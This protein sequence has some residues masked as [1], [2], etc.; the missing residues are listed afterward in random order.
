MTW[1]FYGCSYTAGHE[2]NDTAV[3]NE[4]GTLT[5]PVTTNK[6]Y[7]QNRKDSWAGT[8]C[9]LKNVEFCNRAEYGSS[10]GQMMTD[11]LSDIEQKNIERGDV[12]VWAST[13]SRRWFDIQ[14]N[15]SKSW[16]PTSLEMFG[17]SKQDYLLETWSDTHLLYRFFL[18]LYQFV[19]I[20]HHEG[21]ECM[22]I[23]CGDPLQ[24]ELRL[25]IEKIGIKNEKLLKISEYIISRIRTN[26][27][28][29]DKRMSFSTYTG[30][31]MDANGGD[32]AKDDWYNPGGHPTKKAHDCW[33]KLVYQ[34]L[35]S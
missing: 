19:T 22:I 14:D 21:Y 28:L 31:L 12:V 35:E 16:V 32:T 10:S 24:K 27:V 7:E 34:H 26:V 33:A 17:G 4:D 29:F 13:F 20:C 15:H 8:L 5:W 2:I 23:P 9:K 3:R 25:L 11:F 1:W 30:D 18:D 6:H